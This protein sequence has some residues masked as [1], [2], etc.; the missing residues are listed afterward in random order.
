M[1]NPEG[2]TKFHAFI[3]SGVTLTGVEL[4]AVCRGSERLYLHSSFVPEGAE[5]AAKETCGKFAG[6]LHPRLGYNYACVLDKGHEGDCRKGGTCFGHGPYVGENCPHWPSCAHT[7]GQ[8]L[9]PEDEIAMLKY[10]WEKSL[11]RVA[12]LETTCAYLESELA[13]LRE[14]NA[15]LELNA[16]SRCETIDWYMQQVDKLKAE[17]QSLEEKAWIDYLWRLN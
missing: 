16:R 13:S 8:E 11:D 17:L 9:P 15:T 10:G 7:V 1:S 3:P 5:Q 2:A 6:S 12:E 4:C 14:Q